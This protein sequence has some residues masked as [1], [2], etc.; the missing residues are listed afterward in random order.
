MYYNDSPNVLF[1]DKY[2]IS[3]KLHYALELS[4]LNPDIEP[5]HSDPGIE[6]SV[7]NPDIV[8]SNNKKN[9]EQKGIYLVM[10]RVLNLKTKVLVYNYVY[11]PNFFLETL[12]V[13]LSSRCST[14][15]SIVMREWGEYTCILDHN[16]GGLTA[17]LGKL[18]LN[19]Y[20]R[21]LNEI[22]SVLGENPF[23]ATNWESIFRII[24][25]LTY[26]ADYNLMFKLIDL[27]NNKDYKGF[28]KEIL[29]PIK[30]YDKLFN[31]LKDL[32]VEKP[33]NIINGCV[34]VVNDLN[35]FINNLTDKGLLVNCGPQA[36]R[37]QVNSI[38][39]FLTC[40]DQDF[41]RVLY[42]HNNYHVRV[43]NIDKNYILTRDKF[44]F[45]NIHIN[46]GRVHYYSTSVKP[47]NRD[48]TS[49]INTVKQDK[50]FLTL[51][52]FKHLRIFLDNNP[53]NVNT[54][55][56]IESFILSQYKW[57][58]SIKP[59]YSVLDINMDLFTSK[60]NNFFLEKREVIYS[61]LDKVKQNN[62]TIYKLKSKD[63]LSS[64][65]NMFYLNKI[66]NKL[67]NEKILDLILYN[68]FKLV[69]Y[70]N[71]DYENIN[72]LNCAID[73]GKNICREYLVI[74]YKQSLISDKNIPFSVW[75]TQN[76]GIVQPFEDNTVLFDFIGTRI[77]VELLIQADLVYEKIIINK[78]EKNKQFKIL[79][80]SKEVLQIIENN[81]IYVVPLKLP[82]IVEPKPYTSKQLG[83][84]LL[85][86]VEK[87][88][89]LLINK[90]NYK[91]N[92]EIIKGNIIY[93][94]V[95]NINKTC[96][97]I[98]KEV[99]DF[100]HEYGVEY[101]LIEDVN[102]KHPL[103]NIKRNNRQDKIYRAYK[104]KIILEQNILGVADT[105]ANMSIYFPV[106]LDQRGR[107][108]CE[109]LYF[110]YQSSELAKS[111]I[112]FTFPGIINRKDYN[113][114][115][116]LKAY[117]ANCYGHGIDKKSYTKKIEW[118]DNNIADILDYKNAKLLT[119]AKDKCLFLSFCMEYTR[120][121]EFLEQDSIEFQTYLPIQLDA[122]CNG[123]QHLALL[124]TETKIFKE[125][126][127]SKTS[128]KDDPKDFYS[129]MKNSLNFIFKENSH[130]EKLSDLDRESYNRL[131][132]FPWDRKNIKQAIMTLPY[133]ASLRS[134]IKYI[135]DTLNICE[136]N[137]EEY[138]IYKE[139]EKIRKENERIRK[140]KLSKDKRIKK[141]TP[142]TRWF[143]LIDQAT[144]KR[145]INNRDIDLLGKAIN[146]I[147]D[148]DFP[149]ITK[150]S[151]YLINV[152]GICNSIGIPISWALPHGL[153]INQSYLL[154]KTATI[155]PFT[156]LKSS[157][158]LKVAVN[159]KFDLSK[160]KIA[161]MPNLI[162]SLDATS[163]SLLYDRFYDSHK[164]IVNFYAIHDC[165]TTT[166]DKVDSLI[167]L[168]KTVYLSLYTED[169]YL[170]K[171]D[172]GIIDSIKYHY[173]NDC[174]YNS[175]NRTFTI[176]KKDY[177]LYDIEEVLG[178]NL[179][180]NLT[181][182]LIKGSQ[183]LVI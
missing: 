117:G 178:K 141:I 162:H 90:A 142:I 171:F 51:S 173:G 158:K 97:K 6:L 18:D 47:V 19:R 33:F 77:F 36:Q 70:N 56:K 22:L 54:Q 21:Q 131:S 29:N 26:L 174:V 122:T 114:I 71:S 104:S 58:E 145:M 113:A 115:E 154:T 116:Y 41:R 8:N 129:Y 49:S 46:I 176:G 98:N 181:S 96:Y 45:K 86:D 165:F 2:I 183:Y 28:A 133:N 182:D 170:R 155:K 82:M 10:F 112:S 144:P 127:I 136:L 78:E 102:Q 132:A 143:G 119:K 79:C 87:T 31:S 42:N 63:I 67:E 84:Y 108:Y 66:I 9:K 15:P 12:V 89:N 75:K 48:R 137:E 106:R 179:P 166:C 95:N 59:S 152:A 83:G 139:N 53:L 37:G 164:P 100:I 68:F 124:S 120:F 25:K 180:T 60:F 130:N 148:K 128:K 94:M 163:L 134:I 168:L 153:H 17:E 93:D 14:R 7:S 62:K 103:E 146:D 92:S 3:E 20:N 34:F 16:M 13:Y 72:E 81:K 110:N 30:N 175:D 40:I 44:S 101:G 50:E 138:E 64:K 32:E 39:N 61:Y 88:E 35:L 118:V 23:W 4:T 11:Y 38:T 147:I 5:S 177:R 169:N 140:E 121:T 109:P 111:L 151:D 156:F 150:L 126:N 76:E 172:K 159:T 105:F 123:F 74:L 80:L 149:K 69:T 55:K 57:W 157:F 99:L 65:N 160:Q 73:F 125:L 24:N 52:I 27:A 85:N 1:K 135:K 107:I 43:G 167:D 161:L 91:Q